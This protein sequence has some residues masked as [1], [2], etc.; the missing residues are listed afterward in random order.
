MHNS[1]IIIYFCETK[2]K[3][4]KKESKILG[5]GIDGIVLFLMLLFMLLQTSMIQNFIYKAVVSELSNK[6]HTKV[7]VGKIEYKLFNDIAV[8]T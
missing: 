6:L 2:F 5:F 8:S 3:G 7:T 4:I 1:Q